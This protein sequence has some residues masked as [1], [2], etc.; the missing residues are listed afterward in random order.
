MNLNPSHP[1]LH[2]NRTIHKSKVVAV[3]N[4]LFKKASENIKLGGK[5]DGL[6]TKGKLRGY[7]MFSLTLQ[8]RATCPPTCIHWTDCFGNN[9]AFAHRFE[10]GENLE[11]ELPIQVGTLLKKNPKGVLIRLHVLGD[12]YSREY[13]E[14]W[15]TLLKQ[16]EKLAIFGYSARTSNDP[17]GVALRIQGILFPKQSFIRYSVNNYDEGRFIA[18]NI[19]LPGAI[20][21]PEQTGKTDSC[22]TCSFCW[23]TKIPVHFIT[24]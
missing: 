22:T 5:G 14:L 20:T 1:A 24:H 16:H 11:K 2:E 12:F 23:E 18:T 9:M 13:V 17:I 8:E 3:N 21:C 15:S 7:K 4:R 19:K 6:V 10:H